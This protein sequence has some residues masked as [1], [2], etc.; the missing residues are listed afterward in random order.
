MV[1]V[2][3]M[4]VKKLFTSQYK[5]LQSAVK[6]TFHKSLGKNELSG[7]IKK[8]MPSKYSLAQWCIQGLVKHLRWNVLQK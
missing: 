7:G 1:S 6:D 2:K 5:V 3:M 4:E 8:H